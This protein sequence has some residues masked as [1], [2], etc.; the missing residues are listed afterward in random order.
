MPKKNY[1]EIVGKKDEC[2]KQ[3]FVVFDLEKTEC[4]F[5]VFGTLCFQGKSTYLGARWV[6]A[7]CWRLQVQK[8][9]K[10]VEDKWFGDSK[11]DIFQSNL[12]TPLYPRKLRIKWFGQF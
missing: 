7:F 4:E 1:S 3:K 8:I 9:G 6:E 2:N 12:Y 10:D 5:V 11:C